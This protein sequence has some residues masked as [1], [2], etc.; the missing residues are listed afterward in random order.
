MT[1]DLTCLHYTAVRLKGNKYQGD[2]DEHP[3][4]VPKRLG[5]L[6]REA[7]LAFPP[8][9]TATDWYRSASQQVLA[10]RTRKGAQWPGYSGHGELIS[11]DL[12]VKASIKAIGGKT[13]N[14]LD[15][16]MLQFGWVCHI[17]S[18]PSNGFE[19]WH[20]NYL[21]EMADAVRKGK[22]FGT[23]S[24]DELEQWIRRQH[25]N[26]WAILNPS[27]FD[28]R[29][30][31]QEKRDDVMPLQFALQKAGFYEYEVDGVWGKLSAAA[32]AEAAHIYQSR[33]IGGK[34]Y[35]YNVRRVLAFISAGVKV[36]GEV[37]NNKFTAYAEA[38]PVV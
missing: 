25:E 17:L 6:T 4:P 10:A 19:E 32:F 20:Y 38:E 31:Y 3:R 1:D 33:K 34:V 15:D 21:P 7:A 28:V 5:C 29:T 23:R 35:Y 22:H 18:R 12:N 2:H 30:H 8:L 26:D 36:I 14:D 27:N 11:S 24:S 9:I 37:E 13:K 16:Y